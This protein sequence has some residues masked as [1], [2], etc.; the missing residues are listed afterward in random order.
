VCAPMVRKTS[1]STRHRRPCR[2]EDDRREYCSLASY[3]SI[4]PLSAV[5]STC[6]S[7]EAQCHEPT[8][9]LEVGGKRCA[10]IV[11]RLHSSVVGWCRSASENAA[12]EVDV[13]ALPVVLRVLWMSSVVYFAFK[14]AS[15]L[16]C[17][18]QDWT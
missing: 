18:E 10:V 14:V 9:T 17:T 2:S 4:P 3:P 7:R 1:V 16:A 13:V 5:V 15:L 11:E 8:L 12:P 6:R